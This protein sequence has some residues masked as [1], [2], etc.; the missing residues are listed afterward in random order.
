[1]LVMGNLGQWMLMFTKFAKSKDY[2]ALTYV[3]S[4]FVMIQ[5][6]VCI[7]CDFFS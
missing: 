3:D 1:M 2:S 7:K 4:N 6:R 5:M